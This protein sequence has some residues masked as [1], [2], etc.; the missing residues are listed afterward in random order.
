MI[1]RGQ[2]SGIIRC[3]GFE[4]RI[5]SSEGKGGESWVELEGFGESDGGT[6][7]SNKEWKII[8]YFEVLILYFETNDFFFFFKCSKIVTL[9]LMDGN[10]IKAFEN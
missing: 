7:E 4:E 1:C 8:F 2:L 10:N 9:I 3:Q 5:E 6:K